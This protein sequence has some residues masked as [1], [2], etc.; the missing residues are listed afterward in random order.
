MIL[1]SYEAEK[2]TK[3]F[4]K[5][6]FYLLYGENVGIKKDIKGL[7]KKIITEKEDDIEVL[8]LYENEIIEKDENF[9][10]FAYS[11][12]LFANKKI[13]TIYNATDKILDRLKNVYDKKQDNL[14]L[15]IFS[16]T[17][18]KKSKLRVFFE[19]DKETICIPC[20]LD[21]ERD[22]ENIVQLELKKNNIFLSREAINLLIEK[23]NSDRNNLRNEIEKIKTYSLN[24]K[25]IEF[26][27]LKSLINFSGDYKSDVLVNE[28]L[29]GNILQYKKIISELYSNTVNQILLFR[30]LSNKVQRLLKIK[31]QINETNSL[32]ELI[33]ITKPPI[34]WKEKAIVKKQLTRWSLFELKKII[35]NIN[36]IELLC[37]KN[38]QISKVIFFNFFLKICTKTNNYS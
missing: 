18:E 2:K 11:G 29:S 24:K 15:I 9:F 33:N 14:I 1:K 36:N 8:T 38:P 10:N 28:C 25:K 5:Y 30:I 4:L 3:E 37:K 23:S 20:Y 17:L 34:F 35:I 21:N 19:K 13:I 12:S 6:N 32:D 22:L 16:D 26:D 27:E 7:I 31:S